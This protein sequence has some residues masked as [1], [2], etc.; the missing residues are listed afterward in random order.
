MNF[1]HPMNFWLNQNNSNNRLIM[2]ILCRNEI[3]IIEYNIR[4]HA[5][6]GVD[7]FLVMDNGSNDGTREL[8]SELAKGFDLTIIDQKEQAYRQREWMTEMAHQARDRLGA[9]WVISNDADEFWIPN[10][11]NIKQLLRKRDSVVTVSRSNMVLDER[12]LESD[13]QFYQAEYRVKYPVNYD[14]EAQ[15]KDQ[16]ISMMLAPLGPKVIVNPYGLVHIKGG[17]HRAKHLWQKYSGRVESQLKVYHYPIRSYEQFE[18]NIAQRKKLLDSGV[19]AM[20]C[21]YRRWVDLYEKGMLHEEFERMIIDG[22]KREV[23]QGIG[24]ITK[25]ELPSFIIAKI[26]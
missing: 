17:N 8:L 2:T 13:W 15:Q 7:A 10:K 14:T 26:V 18:T 23:L 21:H 9:Q 5:Y 3:D 6:L 4:V 24:V 22:Q 11:G 20:G 12:A 25:D 1:L 19:R 16:S